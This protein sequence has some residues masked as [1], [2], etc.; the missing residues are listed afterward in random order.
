MIIKLGH[1]I[2]YKI[3]SISTPQRVVQITV[4]CMLRSI[5]ILILNNMIVAFPD[6]NQ[7]CILHSSGMFDSLNLP[8][9]SS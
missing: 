3:H 7:V 9:L 5:L 8:Q 6:N 2:D 4:Y 1:Y